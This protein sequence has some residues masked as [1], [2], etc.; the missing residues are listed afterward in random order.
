MKPSHDAFSCRAEHQHCI[1]DALAAA[2]R[3]CQKRSSRL[4]PIRRRVLELI[5]QSHKPLGAYDL[6]P[7]LARDGHNSA[8][9]TVY[10]ALD[11][12]LEQGLIH[13]L[14]S[15]NAYIGCSA[16]QQAHQGFFL[17]CHQ[18]GAA[19]ELNEETISAGIR[20]CAR[21]CRFQIA[22]ATVEV[23]GLCHHCQSSS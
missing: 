13:R 19:Q 21:D 22:R 20:A 14:A 2:K 8:P 23:T 3:L 10:R 18:C 12:L 15:L 9:P 7:L 1:D 17:I 16:P 5:W 6:L 4:T 11:F